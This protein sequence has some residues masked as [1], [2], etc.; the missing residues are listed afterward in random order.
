MKKE[1]ND[2]QLG[3]ILLRT[4]PRAKHYTLRVSGG[5][6]VATMPVQ[7]DE[8]RLFSFIEE[9]RSKLY[10]LLQNRST[11]SRPL[12]ES[13][14]DQYMTFRLHIF[15]TD[16]E[17]FYMNLNQGILHIACP[18]NTCFE[19]GHVQTILRDFIERALRHEAKR[20]LPQRLRELA[21]R[22]GFTVRHIRINKSRSRWGSCSSNKDINLSLSVMT[23][24]AHLV[25]YILLHELCHTIELNHSDRFWELMD[26][27]TQNRAIQLRTELRK[28]HTV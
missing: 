9:N 28:Y 22:Y 25:D 19:D 2:K 27:V 11:F 23:L 15:R 20:V 1:I 24:P 3:T 4:H 6:V 10:T 17:N 18:Q 16:R 12:N 26:K 8:I 14:T 21:Q 13:S 7:G 5:K